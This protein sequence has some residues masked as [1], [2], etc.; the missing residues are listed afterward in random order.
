MADLRDPV[1][2]YNEVK[3][4]IM[5]IPKS[6]LA[7]M[8]MPF[9]EAMQDRALSKGCIRVSDFVCPVETDRQV[10]STTD[11]SLEIAQHH[12]QPGAENPPGK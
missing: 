9:E 10:V 1:E 5:S 3:N 4:D 2:C 6:D 8:N 11:A 12:F 7:V